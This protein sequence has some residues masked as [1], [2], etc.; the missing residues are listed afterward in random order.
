MCVR[1]ILFGGWISN[2]GLSVGFNQRS[3]TF[4]FGEGGP[5]KVVDEANPLGGQYVF[6]QASPTASRSPLPKGEGL[7]ARL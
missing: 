1:S 2:L 4:S 5:P 6:G 7:G 3:K